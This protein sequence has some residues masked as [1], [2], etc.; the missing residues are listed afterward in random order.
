MSFLDDKILSKKLSRFYYP[1][2]G[3]PTKPTRLKFSLLILKH[4]C[5]LSDREAIEILKRD[6]YFQYF[7]DISLPQVHTHPIHHST[8]SLFRKQIGP[9]GIKIL[10]DELFRFL[11]KARTFYKTAKK[12]IKQQHEIYKGKHVKERIVSL[13]A[14][15]LRPMV[16]GK[17]PQDVEFGPKILLNMK[18]NFLFFQGYSFNN[19]SDKLLLT[20]SIE[21][22]KTTFGHI[23]SELAADRGFFSRNN[24]IK[25]KEMG[26]AKVAIQPKGKIIS[27]EKDPPFAKR[28]RRRR[29]AIEAK[30]SLAKRCFGLN[31]INYRIP[32]GEE[33]W[34]RLGLLAMNYH[35]AMEYG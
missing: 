15:H 19:T 22:Y 21:S 29:C 8:L 6:I 26:I 3:K 18:N 16:R 17:Y 1:D 28:L 5:K 24:V 27:R 7:C 32:H 11:K 20:H 34:I 4:R 23:P 33:I 12:F 10:E 35:I 30:I 2:N 9:E 13:W 25:S 31:K 14:P